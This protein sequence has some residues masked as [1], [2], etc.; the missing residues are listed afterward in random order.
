MDSAANKALGN[1]L[2]VVRAIKRKLASD[3]RKCEPGGGSCS[4][5]ISW[6]RYAPHHQPGFGEGFAQ[7]A[8]VPSLGPP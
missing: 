8:D 1:S 6:L 2:D 7:L 5:N 3:G 4:H